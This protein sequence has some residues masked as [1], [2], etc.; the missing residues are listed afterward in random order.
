ML[1][2]NNHALPVQTVQYNYGIISLCKSR[3]GWVE[4]STRETPG[5]TYTYIYIYLNDGHIHYIFHVNYG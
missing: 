1:R 5:L 2:I 4:Q 3:E